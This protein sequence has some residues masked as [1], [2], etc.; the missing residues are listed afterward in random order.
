MYNVL[1]RNVF[2][3]IN[4]IYMSVSVK[5]R[6]EVLK[7]Y[8]DK[9]AGAVTFNNIQFVNIKISWINTCTTV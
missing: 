5:F 4:L 7:Y 8:F 9:I 3:I 1:I 2:I 6:Y